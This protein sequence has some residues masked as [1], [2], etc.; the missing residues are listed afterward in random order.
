MRTFHHL[1]A[2]WLIAAMVLAVAIGEF[3]VW[4]I[5]KM[6]GWRFPS[7]AVAAVCVGIV[8]ALTAIFYD[9]QE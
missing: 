4:Q 7:I 5:T 2:S 1:K 3:T 6:M 8:A 9:G